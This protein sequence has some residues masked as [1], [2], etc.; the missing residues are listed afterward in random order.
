[1]K[2]HRSA[3]PLPRYV[4]RKPLKSGWAY[5]FDVPT[6]AR[7]AGCPVKN[8]P[9]GSDYDAAVTR[10]EKVLLLAFDSW[11]TSGASDTE[12]KAV[13]A[14]V[15]TLDWIFAEY[16][17]DRRFTKLDAKTK[18]IH[19]VG[20]RMVG[21]Y[22]LKDGRRLGQ[23]RVTL[24]DT[25]AVDDLYAKLLTVQETAPDGKIVERERRTSVNNA[26]KSCRRAWNVARR[27][28]PRKVPFDNPFAKM[29]LVSSDRETPT[30]TYAELQAFRATA[31]ER[32]LSSL[33]ITALIA[34]EWLQRE[35][36]HLVSARRFSRSSTH[37]RPQLSA[38]ATNNLLA[39]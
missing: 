10:A 2:P 21:N 8:E 19:E 15:N 17:A 4:R 13:V 28:N 29:G 30:A 26:M 23:V 12:T 25:G 36:S 27:R 31:K 3:L 34:W 24:I 22:V 16:R 14:A 6:W 7:K 32:G 38:T 5:F 39:V 9:L 37:Y 11:L 33:A 1:M 35:E 18:R 20:F